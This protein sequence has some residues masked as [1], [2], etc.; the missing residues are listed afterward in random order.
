MVY[1]GILSLDQYYIHTDNHAV[2]KVRNLNRA[3]IYSVILNKGETYCGKG[4]GKIINT[5]EGLREKR[6]VRSQCDLWYTYRQ[7]EAFIG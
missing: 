6:F 2:T 7:D 5:L 4:T 3:F 1:N